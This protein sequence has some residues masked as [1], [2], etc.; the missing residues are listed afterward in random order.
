M[1]RYGIGQAAASREAI[2]DGI[3]RTFHEVETALD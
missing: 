1:W 3:G 2:L